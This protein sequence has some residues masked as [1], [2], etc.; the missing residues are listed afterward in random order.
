MVVANTSEAFELGGIEV[1]DPRSARE[2]GRQILAAGPHTVVITMGAAGGGLVTRDQ[3]LYFQGQSVN[4]V[5]AQG[6]GDAFLG[7]LV[8]RLA[9]GDSLEQAAAFAHRVAAFSVTQPG[10][11]QA[12]LPQKNNVSVGD[13]V[14]SRPIAP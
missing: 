5:D 4:V 2:C 7:T 13:L 3:S 10:S 14:A 12:S 6:A 1:R 11:T 9:G 8:A